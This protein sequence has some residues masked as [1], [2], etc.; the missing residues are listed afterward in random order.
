[1]YNITYTQHFPEDNESNIIS[2]Y[3]IIQH[4]RAIGLETHWVFLEEIFNLKLKYKMYFLI[5]C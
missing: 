1:M 3:K 4:C 2:N 5:K